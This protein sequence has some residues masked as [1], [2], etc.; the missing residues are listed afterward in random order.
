MHTP[1]E[2]ER[3]APHPNKTPERTLEIPMGFSLCSLN[4][5]LK[6]PP[7]KYSCQA[8]PV[9]SSQAPMFN[10]RRTHPVRREQQTHASCGTF[11]A[12]SFKAFFRVGDCNPPEQEDHYPIGCRR[13]GGVRVPIEYVRVTCFLY[14][15]RQETGPAIDLPSSACGT[16][17]RQHEWM[18]YFLCYMEQRPFT[19]HDPEAR[20]VTA[21]MPLPVPSRHK[22]D[23]TYAS[24][25]AGEKPAPLLVQY[26][27]T[28]WLGRLPAM[29]RWSAGYSMWALFVIRIPKQKQRTNRET[30]WNRAKPM[31]PGKHG[32]SDSKGG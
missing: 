22:S 9:C 27:Q 7:L 32:D 1:L 12:F 31:P 23:G 21:R 30:T 19:L 29:H 3:D 16:R 8:K 5:E 14:I 15:S 25:E 13:G 11:R 10:N 4:R 24:P 26:F 18:P 6:V 20:R 2:R 28:P 17:I